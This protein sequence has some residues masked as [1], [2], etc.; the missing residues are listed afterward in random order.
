[1]IGYAGLRSRTEGVLATRHLEDITL[2]LELGDLPLESTHSL[3]VDVGRVEA[4]VPGEAVTLHP[5]PE[6]AW[7]D[8]KVPGHL[9]VGLAGLPDYVDRSFTEVPVVL[10]SLLWHRIS[11]RDASTERGCSRLTSFKGSSA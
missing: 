6:C 4:L 1:M 8:P 7:M 2:H 11:L 5:R 3:G 10:P 9:G